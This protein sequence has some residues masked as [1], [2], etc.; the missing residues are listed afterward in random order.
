[1]ANA[2]TVC[3]FLL[4]NPFFCQQTPSK[5]FIFDENFFKKGIDKAKRV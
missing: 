1:M 3:E 2:R 4:A 5:A